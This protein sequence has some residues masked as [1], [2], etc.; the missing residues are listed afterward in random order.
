MEIDDMLLPIP[1]E[2]LAKILYADYGS[3]ALPINDPGRIL[4]LFYPEG[5]TAGGSAAWPSSAFQL[6]F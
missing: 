5:P 4:E 1:G 3:T 6:P 2:D